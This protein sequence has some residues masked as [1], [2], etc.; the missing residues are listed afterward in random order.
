MECKCNT[1]THEACGPRLS[2]KE[3]RRYM[4][5]AIVNILGD[6]PERKGSL[7]EID[8]SFNFGELYQNDRQLHWKEIK[9]SGSVIAANKEHVQ[10]SSE[11]V[12]HCIQVVDMQLDGE[13]A[14]VIVEDG[15]I[16]Q[17][18]VL[19]RLKS[20]RNRNMHCLVIIWG[21]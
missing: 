15:G 16:G 1:H 6:F 4:D 13:N 19:L 12:I 8:Q 3:E 17:K 11:A 2:E 7:E 10:F 5:S 18:N 9:R 21:Q 20:L 14:E